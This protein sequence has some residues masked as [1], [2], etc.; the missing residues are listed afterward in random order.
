MLHIF[1]S[2][3]DK[4]IEVGLIKFTDG[5]KLEGGIVSMVNERIV[6]QNDLSGWE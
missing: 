4:G 2:D 6:L 3:L 1:I 5:R